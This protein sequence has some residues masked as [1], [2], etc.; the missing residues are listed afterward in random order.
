MILNDRVC[1]LEKKNYCAQPPKLGIRALYFKLK[2]YTLYPKSLVCGQIKLPK[3][4][5]FKV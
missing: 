5:L 2:K 1:F 4:L 3:Y